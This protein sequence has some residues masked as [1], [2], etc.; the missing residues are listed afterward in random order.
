MR[1]NKNFLYCKSMKIFLYFQ[2]LYKLKQKL[3]FITLP[4]FR[5]KEK[6]FVIWQTS[7][8]SD[9][10]YAETELAHNAT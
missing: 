2:R 5:N 3:I 4:Q 9:I 6:H 10:N 7:S 8:Y 1:Q